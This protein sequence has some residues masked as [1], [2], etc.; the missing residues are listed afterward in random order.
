MFSNNFI[1][2]PFNH[3]FFGKSVKKRQTNDFSSKA[4]LHG[5]TGNRSNYK[6]III[7]NA[8]RNVNE[9]RLRMFPLILINSCK[10]IIRKK[11]S[12]R[13]KVLLFDEIIICCSLLLP[14]GRNIYLISILQ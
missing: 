3:L 7:F 8:I 1:A 2:G 10:E 5:T 12:F 14:C 4:W 9:T 11:R 13:A 6:I